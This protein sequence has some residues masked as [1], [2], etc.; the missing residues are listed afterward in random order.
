M[1][2]RRQRAQR[3]TAVQRYVRLIYIYK[4]SPTIRR[5]TDAITGIVNRKIKDHWMKRYIAAYIICTK[6]YQACHVRHVPS[7]QPHA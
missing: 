6:M 4:R 1:R 2:A 5:D 7:S 3:L